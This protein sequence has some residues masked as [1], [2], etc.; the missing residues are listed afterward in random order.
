MSDA[1][2]SAVG[3]LCPQEM[4]DGL[5]SPRQRGGENRFFPC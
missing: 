2:A 4:Q 5:E 3:L 1:V